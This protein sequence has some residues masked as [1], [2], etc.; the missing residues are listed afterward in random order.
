M[1]RIEEFRILHEQGAMTKETI[2]ESNEID[3]FGVSLHGWITYA[4]HGNTY[5]FRNRIQDNFFRKVS[6]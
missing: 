5:K 3:A 2:D 6:I 1:R 4:M